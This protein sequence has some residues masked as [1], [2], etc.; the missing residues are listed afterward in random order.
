MIIWRM[1]QRVTQRLHDIVSQVKESP[2]ARDAYMMWEEKIFYERRDAKEEGRQ[3]T[4]RIIREIKTLIEKNYSPEQI[5][6]EL[7][8]SIEDVKEYISLVQQ[9]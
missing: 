9:R 4:L 8:I 3:E 6:D 5:V 2:E 7:D 1:L